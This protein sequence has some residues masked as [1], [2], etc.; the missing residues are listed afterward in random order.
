MNI[1]LKS[2]HGMDALNRMGLDHKERKIDCKLRPDF[3]SS[4]MHGR[5]S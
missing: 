1:M 3:V 5:A 2:N 4:P